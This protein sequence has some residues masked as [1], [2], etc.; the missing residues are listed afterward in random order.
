MGALLPARILAAPK[1][2]CPGCDKEIFLASK[3]CKECKEHGVDVPQGKKEAWPKVFYGGKD[4][5]KG[6]DNP[7]NCA[8]L[9]KRLKAIRDSKLVVGGGVFGWRRNGQG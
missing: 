8:N 4:K 6:L 9:E 7:Q 5:P 3:L 2:K 1:K